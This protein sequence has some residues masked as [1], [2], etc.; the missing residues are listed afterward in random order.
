MGWRVNLHRL[1]LE[2]LSQWFLPNGYLIISQVLFAVSFVYLTQY[3]RAHMSAIVY[4]N[5]SEFYAEGRDIRGV[6]ALMTSSLDSM[7]S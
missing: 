1:N 6:V 4:T 5:E 7:L 2:S 3:T